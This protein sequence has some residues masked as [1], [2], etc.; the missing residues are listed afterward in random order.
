MKYYNGF[1]VGTVESFGPYIEYDVQGTKR[2]TYVGTLQRIEDPFVIAPGIYVR[3]GGKLV[4]YQEPVTLHRNVGYDT[5][6]DIDLVT[7]LTCKKAA[8]SK[9]FNSITCLRL[10][11]QRRPSRSVRIREVVDLVPGKCYYTVSVGVET[12][13]LNIYTPGNPHETL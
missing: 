1:V 11:D 13:V 5:V 9:E 7:A 8:F 10:V 4:A 12:W 3:E 2:Q 6:A